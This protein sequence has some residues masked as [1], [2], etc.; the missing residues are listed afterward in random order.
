VMFM[1]RGGS[2]SRFSSFRSS[3][4]G[5]LSPHWCRVYA[6][7][8]STTERVCNGAAIALSKPMC[9]MRGATNGAGKILRAR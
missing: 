2:E 3:L 6:W 7:G 8:P 5:I 9:S 1:E 4:R